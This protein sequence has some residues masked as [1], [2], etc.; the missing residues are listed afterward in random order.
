[1]PGF[2]QNR[3]NQWHKPRR[4]VAVR[5]A[6]VARSGCRCPSHAAA[7]K[8]H[9]AP[10]RWQDNDA[11]RAWPALGVAPVSHSHL[12]VNLSKSLAQ[13]IYLLERALRRQNKSKSNTV[14][15]P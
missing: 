15:G 10:N 4:S 14:I 8:A 12:T 11:Q 5:G 6:A 7:P 9:A 3:V 13:G 1:Y 2:H